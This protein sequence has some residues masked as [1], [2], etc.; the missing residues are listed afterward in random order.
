MAAPEVD[1]VAPPMT[2]TVC[3]FDAATVVGVRGDVDLLTAPRLHETM[4]ALLWSE[5][6][7]V[8]ID[9][10]ATTFFGVSGLAVLADAHRLTGHR[11][12]LRLVATGQLGRQLRL[13]GVDRALPVHPTRADALA[14]T[15]DSG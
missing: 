3:R 11:T 1:I 6:P 10:L 8:V 5:P 15:A 7:V 12:Q 4:I 2:V 14:G 13:S 9:L